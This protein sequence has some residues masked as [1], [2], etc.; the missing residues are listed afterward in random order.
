[1]T[2]E[3]L[4]KI[5]KRIKNDKK[6]IFIIILGITGMLLIMLSESGGESTQAKARS[7]S[8]QIILSEKELAEDVEQFVESIKGAGKA[9]V[10]LTFE[11]FEETVYAVDKD[12]NVSSD[13]ETDSSG[14]YVIIDNGSAEDGLKLKILSPK[15]RGVA[16]ICKGGSSPVIKEQ[17]TTALSALFDISTNRIS[18]AEMAD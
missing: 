14:Q 17:I 9:K 2:T 16:V 5:L 6:V 7:E 12:E 4:K 18:V 1:M 13:G 8:K 15:I 3:E 10:I 11:S